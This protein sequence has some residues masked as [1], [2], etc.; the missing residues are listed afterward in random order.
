MTADRT[1]RESAKHGAAVDPIA[2]QYNRWIYPEPVRDLVELSSR[3][4]ADP[5]LQHRLYWPDRDYPAGLTILVAGCGANQAAEIAFHNRTASVLGIDVSAASLAHERYLKDRHGLE[6]LELQ[7]LRLEDVGQLARAF[8]LIISTGVLHHLMDPLAG[9]RALGRCLARDGVIVMLLYAKYGRPGVDLLRALFAMLE[10]R[11]DDSAL[12]IIKETLRTLSPSHP[13]VQQVRRGD[14]RDFRFDAG[15]IDLFLNARERSYTARDCVDLVAAAGLAFQGWF[16]NQQFYPEA[17]FATR[18][19]PLYRA[20][21]ALDRVTMWSAMECITKPLDGRHMFLACRT[22]RPPA[23]YAIDFASRAYLDYVPI[24]AAGATTTRD[25]QGAVT[26]RRELASARL[27]ANQIALLK[28]ANSARSIRDIVNLV[29]PPEAR[30]RMD[31]VEQLAQ[32]FFQ[33]LWALDIIHVRLNPTT[34]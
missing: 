10:L 19:S 16:Q 3:Q 17:S 32:E 31:Q 2:A 13:A 27:D 5:A 28:Q 20:L 11:Q 14:D 18:D 9:L 24:L 12:A 26:I 25:D 1:D 22:D 34:S 33:R 6:N 29:T 23:H 4:G 21:R 7:L 15:L 30:S 8:D